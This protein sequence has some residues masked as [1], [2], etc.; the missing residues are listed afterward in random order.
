MIVRALVYNRVELFFMFSLLLMQEYGGIWPVALWAGLSLCAWW[1]IMTSVQYAHEHA[2]DMVRHGALKM[3]D[4]VLGGLMLLVLA[5]I[6]RAEQ[7]FFP[8]MYLLAAAQHLRYTYM[9]SGWQ[10]EN[11]KRNRNNRM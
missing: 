3:Q 2:R 8:V 5:Y 11:A 9:I 1:V 10:K 6:V 4:T 7:W